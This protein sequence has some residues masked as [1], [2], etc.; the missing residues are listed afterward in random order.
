MTS[1]LL[2]ARVSTDRQ[3]QKNQLLDL[4][5]VA[6]RKNYKIVAEIIEQKSA[7]TTD[8]AGIQQILTR[9]DYDV[10]LVW[11]L[12]R[13]TREGIFPTIQL[14]QSLKGKGVKVEFVKDSILNTLDNELVFYIMLTVLSA[15]AQSEREKI[16]ERTKAGLRRARAEGKHL[17]RP[18]CTVSSDRKRKI[19]QFR[20]AGAS[21]R[22]IGSKVRLSKS[23]VQRILSENDKKTLSQKR[24]QKI[25]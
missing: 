20:N 12:D 7:R 25:R 4:R 15:L 16:S 21:I 2:Y 23:S 11:S 1:A 8:R 9:N 17:G 19:I 24:V 5:A 6:R 10:L 22:V 13:L 14:L 18:P 3:D